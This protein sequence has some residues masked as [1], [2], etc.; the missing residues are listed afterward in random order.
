[1]AMCGIAAPEPEATISS[2]SGLAEASFRAFGGDEPDAVL[3]GLGRDRLQ[4]EFAIGVGVAEEAHRLH[5]QLHH[6]ADHGVGHNAVA[7]RQAEDPFLLRR[8]HAH[9]RR[10]Q[11]HGPALGRHRRH[12]CGHGRDA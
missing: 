6:V 10:G 7:L 2:A 11:L 9:R 5:S 12:R 8:R 4:P 3:L 1:M